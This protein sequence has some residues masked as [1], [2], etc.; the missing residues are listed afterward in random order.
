ME[1]DQAERMILDVYH[2]RKSGD[3]AAMTTN[4]HENGTYRL[5]AGPPESSAAFMG[6]NNKQAI[7]GTFAALMKEYI[8]ED[9]WKVDRFVHDDETSVLIWRSTVTSGATKKSH[10]FEVCTVVTFKDGK[11][12]SATEHTDTAAIVALNA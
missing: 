2:S 12:L 4:F 10:V 5:N 6:G 7:I 1:R 3:A 11:I 8:F 9:D